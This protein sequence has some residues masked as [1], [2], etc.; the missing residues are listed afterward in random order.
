MITREST[1]RRVSGFLA[2]RSI[3]TKAETRTPGGINQATGGEGASMR[4][5]RRVGRFG[6]ICARLAA[7]GFL[8]TGAAACAGP[9]TASAPRPASASLSP[10]AGAVD[11]QP[12][13]ITAA[14][15]RYSTRAVVG[16][17]GATT[18]G[19]SAMRAGNPDGHVAVPAAAQAVDTSHPDHV[20][21]DGTPAGCTSAAV[22][23]AVAEGGIIAFDCGPKPVTIT[24]T[25]TAKVVNTSHQVVLDGGG[26]VTLSGGDSTRI[27]YMN[28]CDS[29]Q[30][31]TTSECWEQ[32]WPQLV[33]QNLTFTNAYSATQQSKTASYGGG[34]IFDEGGQL[35]VVNSVFSGDRCY[36]TG[37][38]LGGGAIRATGM[39]MGIPVYIVNDTFTGNS[40]SNG[41]ALSGL[42]A[43]FAVYN[44]L[45][46]GNKAIGSGAN[47]AK[48]GTPGGGSGG[49][50]YTDGAGYNLLVDGTAMSGNTA[51]EGGGAIFFVVN[52]G[53]GTLTIDNSTLSDNVDHVHRSV[54]E[55]RGLPMTPGRPPER[56][57]GDVGLS[58]G[59]GPGPGRS[60]RCGSALGRQFD[61]PGREAQSWAIACSAVGDCGPV[62]RCFAISLAA[63]WGSTSQGACP[64]GIS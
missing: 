36:A 59:A 46:T 51:N 42:F 35:K 57:D 32:Q 26:K 21:G 29:A 50:I 1:D 41:A 7:A 53:G 54:S 5:M 64:A 18:S 16:T 58:P 19:G 48:S 52:S 11:G 2:V 40:C 49:A 60:P 45:M 9:V 3:F 13:F 27:L 44:S 24:M 63:C 38:D 20:I 34:A 14:R 17:S 28:T 30:I 33:V 56:S 25:A 61:Y 6:Q 23:Q 55:D 31:Y 12:V 10:A 47:P 62:V 15:A 39:D 37:P 43:N 4:A 22:V 8:L